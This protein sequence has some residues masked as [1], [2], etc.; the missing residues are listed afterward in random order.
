MDFKEFI[1]SKRETLSESSLKT[2]ASILKSLYKKVFGDVEMDYEKFSEVEPIIEYLKDIPFNKRK[3]VLSALVVITGLPQY[4]ELMMADVT[5][6][7]AD[8]EKQEPTEAQEENWVL[9]ADIDDKLAESQKTATQLYKKGSLTPADLQNIQNYIILV[10]LGGK[11]FPV[12]RAK[13]FTDFKIKNITDKDNYIQGNEM[14]FNS[15]KTAF[16]YGQQREKI[17]IKL[18]NILKKWIEVNPTDYLLFDVNMNPLTSVKLNQ[19]LNKIFGKKVGVNILRH[20]SL[21]DKF[22]DTIQQ[23]KD[24]AETMASMGSSPSMLTTYVKDIKPK[25]EDKVLKAYKELKP[26]GK[27]LSR[28]DMLLELAKESKEKV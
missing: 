17:P 12:R 1:K 8:I 9:P 25:E 27:K 3:T 23:K 21:T 11:Y 26:K 28:G 2:Y 24:I 10:L 20:S 18:K 7:N 19:R 4:R 5:E 22:G 14:V 6:Y 13:D 15:Y 16:A